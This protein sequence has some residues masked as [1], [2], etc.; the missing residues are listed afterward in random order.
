[1]V[2]TPLV[3]PVDHVNTYIIKAD[4]E[5][6]V[7]DVGPD[8]FL[9]ITTLRKNMKR[10]N[11]RPDRSLF[12]VTHAHRDHIGA[13]R[14]LATT[15]KVYIG[16]NELRRLMRGK[17]QVKDMLAF[18]ME[19]GFPERLAKVVIKLVL[20]AQ[21]KNLSNLVPLRDGELLKLG[22]HKFKCIE[23][24]GHTQGHVC[25]Y[26]QCKGVLFAGDHIL[27]NVTPPIS[28]WSY[29]EDSLSAYLLGLK[30]ICALSPLLVL[31]GHGKPLKNLKERVRELVNHH[32]TRLLEI[33]RVLEAQSGDAYWISSKI[34]WK[35]RH[36]SWGYASL[37]RIWLA[38]EET[39]AHLNF[40]A[41]LGVVDR[42]MVKGRTV[43]QIVNV[44]AV[45]TVK[46][47]IADRLALLEI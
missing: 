9:S 20:V 8:L 2:K 47:A 21:C 31:P 14:R 13:A 10:L 6:V 45:E 12:I 42:K 18:A 11:V 36:P 25:L 38:F 15:S 24:P 35:M 29:E 1:M 17:E 27:R 19:N 34:G 41:G 39:L 16:Y 4:D 28:S 22:R 5:D 43:Y 37:F 33:I 23:T 40:L 46:K 44:D 26:D 3:G 7:I 32:K 30:R